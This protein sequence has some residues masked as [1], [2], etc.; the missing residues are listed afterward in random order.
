MRWLG[1]IAPAAAGIALASAAVGS[2]GCFSPSFEACAVACGAA[3]ECPEGRFCLGDN[4]CHA[5]EEEALCGGAGAGSDGSVIDG[6]LAGGGRPD[7]GE[8]DPGG[9]SDS[10]G[11][12]AGSP[13]TPSIAGQ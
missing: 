6:P 9:G 1:S 10:G 13:I 12:D 3:G 4:K 7:A 11:R 5:S 8:G 2:G